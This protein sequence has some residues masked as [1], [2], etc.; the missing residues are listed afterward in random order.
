MDGFPTHLELAVGADHA[1]HLPGLGTA[2][3]AWE[4]ELDGEDGVV[5]VRWTRGYP[6][7]TPPRRAGLSAPEL[8]TIIGRRPGTVELIFRQR[9]PWEP[10]EKARE[11]HHV[12]VTVL[13]SG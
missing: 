7:D 11:E 10:P 13:P 9:R 3:Y 8:A 6:A 2:G 4:H 5:D 12:S 1:L